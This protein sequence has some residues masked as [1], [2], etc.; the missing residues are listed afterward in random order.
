MHF[1][2][3]ISL[4]IC[5]LLYSS[6]VFASSK[7]TQ[8]PITIEADKAVLDDAKQ[9]GTYIGNVVLK[10]GGIEVRA[11]T[12][13]VFSNK[14]KIQR[15]IAEGDPVHYQQQHKGEVI[16]SESQRMEYDAVTKRVL[17]EGGAELWQGGNRFSGKRIEY[18]P[19]EERVI[20]TSASEGSETDSQRVQITLQPKSPIQADQ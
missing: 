9:T 11:S 2:Y 13:T 5:G 19:N 17:L 6:F 8:Q 15:V 16:Q 1:N 20:A 18:D 3:R 7:D 10:Q 4:C 12:L 14:K